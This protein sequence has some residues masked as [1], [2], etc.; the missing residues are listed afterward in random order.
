MRLFK[1]FLVYQFEEPL[2]L[3]LSELEEALAERPLVGCFEQEMES[4]GWLTAFNS[5]KTFVEAVDGAYFIRM[6]VERKK[7]PRLAIKTAVEKRAEERELKIETRSQYKE[8]EE[9]I[10]NELMANALP[11][12]SSLSAYIDIDKNWLVIDATSVKKASELTGLLRKTLG[13]L[14]VVALAPKVALASVMTEWVQKGITNERFTL[15]DEIEMKE[16]TKE[17]GG[18]AR[19]KGIPA[20]SKEILQNLEDGWDVTRLSLLFNEAVSFSLGED[21]ILKR[22]KYLETFHEELDESDDLYTIA[23]GS[24]QLQVLMFRELMSEL[25]QL[26]HP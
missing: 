22:V 19:Y 3:T 18:T 6:G 24:A 8:V 21:F 16:L 7:L 17:E 12:R 9:V 10:I 14:P 23:A 4:F 2:E 13:T 5:G 20:M 11:E 1:N 25:Y 15:L 26:C